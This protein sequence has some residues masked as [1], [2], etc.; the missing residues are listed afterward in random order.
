MNDIVI[1]PT[2]DRPEYLWVCLE[3]LQR[4]RGIENKEIWVCEDNH[5]DAPKHFT[6]QMEMLATLREANRMFGSRLLYIGRAPHDYYGNSYNVLEALRKAN[7]TEARFVYIVE[8][9]SMVLPDF[10]EWNEQA[11]ER[12]NPSVTCAGRINRSLNFQ[13]NGP[14]AID[15]TIKDPLA[16]VRSHKAYMS[17]ATCF[18]RQDLYWITKHVDH[19]EWRPGWEQD[20][21]IQ[22]F[23]RDATQDGGSV[24]PYVPRAYHMGW[25]SYHRTAGMKFNGTL[26]DKVTALRK[27][28]VD[29]KKINDMAGLQEIDPFPREEVK[30]SGDLYLKAEYR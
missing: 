27:A 18:P 30:W 28:I 21:F 8:D 2:Y 3:N 17:W 10:F 19:E 22:E 14:E 15:E 16:C 26:E 9:D 6:I 24:W 4:S 25:Y 29:K 11:Q 7:E 23:L 12:F 13:M 1:I 5:E 20:I